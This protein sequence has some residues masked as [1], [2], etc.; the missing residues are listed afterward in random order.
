M[1][2]ILFVPCAAAM[3]AACGQE[4]DD[5]AGNAVANTSAASEKRPAYCFFKS[6][7]TKAWKASLE[8]SGDV[9]ISGKAHV[10]DAR[11]KPE[12]GQ[13]KVTG[14]SAEVWPTIAVNTGYASPDN[15]WDVNFTI[16]GSSAVES[17]VVRCGKKTLA[18]LKVR[19]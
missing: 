18:E 12:L 7:E 11:Y 14:T 16:P 3:L 2:P 6:A 9:T 8:R 10:K 15:W 13:P 17:V 19:R 4:A 1:R 5:G